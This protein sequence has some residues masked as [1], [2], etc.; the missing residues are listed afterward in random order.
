MTVVCSSRGGGEKWS[1]PRFT[2]KAE[3]ERFDDR[4]RKAYLFG[5][6]N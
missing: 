2:L 3:M 5:L 6:S 1:E 4:F